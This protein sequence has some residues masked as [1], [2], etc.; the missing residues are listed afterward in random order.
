MGDGTGG[1][2]SARKRGAL[3]TARARTSGKAVE[4]QWEGHGRLGGGGTWTAMEGHGGL[5]GGG[6]H[7]GVGLG[8]EQH[9]R[10]HEGW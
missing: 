5:G 7:L 1:T 4:G 8:R 2:R 10:A 6:T 3:A 9:R